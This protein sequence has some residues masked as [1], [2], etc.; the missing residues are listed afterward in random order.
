MEQS[1][2]TIIILAGA[3]GKFRIEM[4]LTLDAFRKFTF[5]LIPKAKL[6]FEV[7]RYRHFPILNGETTTFF[8]KK[9]DT[10][11]NNMNMEES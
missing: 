2:V 10:L 7:T 5:H 8:L 3:I 9:V 1:R 11:N 4:Y 6:E